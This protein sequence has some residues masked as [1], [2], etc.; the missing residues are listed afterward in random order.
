M[1]GAIWRGSGRGVLRMYSF[2]FLMHFL[3]NSACRTADVHRHACCEA[4][5][6]A[7]AGNRAQRYFLKANPTSCW[8]FYISGEDKKKKKSHLTNVSCKV[9]WDD[10]L[11]MPLSWT[12][13]WS[14]HLLNPP[15]AQRPWRWQILKP[16]LLL[17]EWVFIYGRVSHHP[18]S[19]QPV[20]LAATLFSWQKRK[21]SVPKCLGMS[22]QSFCRRP[23]LEV[24]FLFVAMKHLFTNIVICYKVVI[25]HIKI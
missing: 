16:N 22:C 20:I 5:H 11:K 24:F 9:P 18:A 13:G 1:I 12:R 8:C 4:N 25:H 21:T 10:S 2:F 15:H 23:H 3:L 19:Q 14:P 6:A 7:A 17:S